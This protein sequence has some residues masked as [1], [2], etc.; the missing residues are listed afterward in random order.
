MNK[1]EGMLFPDTYEFSD[2]ATPVEILQKLADQMSAELDEL[3]YENSEAKVGLTP[4]ET[5]IVASLVEKETGTP[6]EERGQIARVIYNRLAAPE[7]LGIDATAV[8][9]KNKPGGELT[10]PELRDPADPFNTRTK[11]GL[12]PTPIGLPSQAS[13]KAAIA[14]EEGAWMYY[15]L[16][17]PGKHAFVETQAEFIELRDKARNQGVIE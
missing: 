6:P 11:Q 15:V 13:L 4:Y 16:V 7:I 14:P 1:W 12:P 10:T 2:D 8:Y 5:V 9:S 3:G 17:E